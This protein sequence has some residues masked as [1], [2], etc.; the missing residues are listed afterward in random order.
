MS[1]DGTGTPTTD[2]SPQVKSPVYVSSDISATP[3]FV[4]ALSKPKKKAPD[5]KVG[6]L[7]FVLKL[8]R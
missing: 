8:Q 5:S 1:R 2:I 3:C 7:F 6:R 4:T